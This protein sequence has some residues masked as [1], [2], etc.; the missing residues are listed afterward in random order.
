MNNAFSKSLFVLVIL[1]FLLTFSGKSQVYFN[2]FDSTEQ[3]HNWHNINIINDSLA[4]NGNAINRTKADNEYSCLLEIPFADSL[5]FNNLFVSFEA[6]FR[7]NNLPQNAIFVFTVQHNDSL[8]FWHGLPLK[9]S[10]S[11]SNLWT[12][13]TTNFLIPTDIALHAQLKAYLWN[14]GKET[15]DIDSVKLE[16]TNQITPVFIPEICINK[17]FGKANICFQNA[18]YQIVY[19]KETGSLIICDAAGIAVTHPISI[20]SSTEN[21]RGTIDYQSSAWKLKESIKQKNCS[22]MLFVCKNKVSTVELTFVADS[23]LSELQCILKSTFRKRLKLKQQSLAICFFDSVSHV[24][25]KNILLDE[26]HF[27]N[28]Y[29]LDKQGVTFGKGNR[30][31]TV[32]HLNEVSSGQV[33]SNRKLLLLNLDFAADH[34][35]INF[36][37]RKDTSNIFTDISENEYHRKQSIASSFSFS[38]GSKLKNLPRFMPVPDGFE[39]AIIWTEHADWSDIRTHRA[40]NFGSEEIDSI[41]NAVGG[42]AKY[43]IPVT[44]S[45]F[46]NNPDKITNN[47]ISNELFNGLHTTIQSDSAFLPF[48]KQLHNAGFEICLHT[49]EQY[50]SNRK[51][52]EEALSFMK[53]EF[54]SSTWIDHGYN[55]KPLNNREDIVCDGLNRKS[56]LF[57][58]DLFDKYGI[59]NF[60]NPYYEDVRPYDAWKFYG[61]L[62]FP[63]P[64]FGDCFPDR[65][66]SENQLKYNGTLWCTASSLEVENSWLWNYYFDPSRLQNLLRYHSVYINHVY[67]AWV[68]EKIGCWT[69]NRDGKI[70]AQESFNQALER[71]HALQLKGKLLPTTISTFINYQTSVLNLSYSIQNDGSIIIVNLNKHKISGLSFITKAKSVSI[72]GKEPKFKQVNDE[73][74]FW[75]DLEAGEKVLIVSE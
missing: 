25:R 34:P 7:M 4:F 37:L 11:T 49:P 33:S 6:Y 41:Q 70:V 59:Q 2:N 65:M 48:L 72:N 12:K 10:I 75:F 53:N 31:V 73:L 38:I 36:P 68:N 52:L 55:N 62:I 19:Y 40:V 71:I 57:A 18:F 69:T 13:L 51:A 3:I 26:D 17:T 35:F 16:I 67:P 1:N 46:Y 14:P 8:L 50:T 9:D 63:F 61:N 66:I 29:Y 5:T 54:A 30:N 21:K 64:G 28:E 43:Q 32:Y 58:G 56:K 44:K 47:L 42:F 23:S 39:A 27:Q 20:F 22:E 60:W 15:I 24:Y 45:V 74:I